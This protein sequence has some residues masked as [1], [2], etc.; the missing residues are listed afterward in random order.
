MTDGF[1]DARTARDIAFGGGSG[2]VVI[3]TEINDVRLAIAEAAANGD[4]SVTLTATTIMTNYDNYNGANTSSYYDAFAG[5]NLGDT[6]VRKSRKMMNLVMSYFVRLGYTM[7]RARDG[8][9][10][11]MNWVINW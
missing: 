11:R 9:N 1:Y 10:N 8:V 4:L 7:T 3:L 5:L 2:N 6:A